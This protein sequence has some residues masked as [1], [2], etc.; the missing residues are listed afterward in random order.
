M[1]GKREH[2]ICL[3]AGALIFSC[4]QIKLKEQVLLGIKPAGFL[5][6]FT[7]LAVLELM[8][9]NSDWNIPTEVPGL[10]LAD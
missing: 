3:L 8:P 4:L 10:Q 7:P 5:L 9:S 2:S 6:A 1:L